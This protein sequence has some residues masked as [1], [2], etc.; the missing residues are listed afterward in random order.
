MFHRAAMLPNSSSDWP[1]SYTPET[2]RHIGLQV[3]DLLS[4]HS[5]LHV[6]RRSIEWQLP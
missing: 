1:E 4:R 3:E 6:Y 5:S 2:L